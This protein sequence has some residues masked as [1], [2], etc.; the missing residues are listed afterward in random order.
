M[1]LV[2]CLAAMVFIAGLGSFAAFG[3]SFEGVT[4]VTG[5]EANEYETRYAGLLKNR[6]ETKASIEVLI[7]EAS[8]QDG[9]TIYLGTADRHPLLRQVCEKRGVRLLVY[10]DG[11]AGR[12]YSTVSESANIGG[13]YYGIL[14]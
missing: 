5:S 3:A 7:S 13:G 8:A 9:L 4:V 6:L 2:C 1:K 11:G 10:I 12:W 14:D